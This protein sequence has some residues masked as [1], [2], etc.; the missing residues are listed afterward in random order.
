MCQVVIIC[1]GEGEILVKQGLI[2]DYQHCLMELRLW[3][4]CMIRVVGVLMVLSGLLTLKLSSI[5]D[6]NLARKSNKSRKHAG[7]G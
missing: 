1:L 3:Y 5:K 2:P 7:R 6:V 4:V